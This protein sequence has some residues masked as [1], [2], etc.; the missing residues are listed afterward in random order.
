MT[1]KAPLLNRARVAVRP[2]T[3]C[4]LFALS[5]GTVCIAEVHGYELGVCRKESATDMTLFGHPTTHLERG[6]VERVLMHEEFETENR[7]ALLKVG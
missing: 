6:K 3:R 5:A 7:S 4:H 1:D 2:W